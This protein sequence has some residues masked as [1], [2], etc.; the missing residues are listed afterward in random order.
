MTVGCKP[1]TNPLGRTY[2]LDTLEVRFRKP[3]CVAVFVEENVYCR[4]SMS[5]RYVEIFRQYLTGFV[6]SRNEG[7]STTYYNRFFLE[8]LTPIIKTGLAMKFF[9]TLLVCKISVFF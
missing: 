3:V 6:Y 5:V 4:P 7:I 2:S 1:L 8:V 9:P